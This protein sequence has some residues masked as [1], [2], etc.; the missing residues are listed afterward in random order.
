MKLTLRLLGLI[1]T[2]LFGTFFIFTYNAPGYVEDVGKDFIKN[3]IEEKTN[4]KIDG[5]KL[6]TADTRLGKI[7]GKLYQKHQQEID[8]AKQLCKEMVKLLQLIR[9]MFLLLWFSGGKLLLK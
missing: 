4:Q 1:G 6:K 3:R 5:I 9:Q 8:K 2:L 7:A